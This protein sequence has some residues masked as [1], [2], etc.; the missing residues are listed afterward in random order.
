[1]PSSVSWLE[2]IELFGIQLGL[3]R[4]HALMERL[5][6]PERHLRTIHVLGTNGK[7]SVTRIA[8]ALLSAEGLSCGSFTSPHVT[9]WSERI[10]VAGREVDFE[11]AIDRVR[12]AAEE[13]GATQFEV[14][15][16]AALAEFA[17]CD[18][19][20]AV[21]E[22]GLGGRLDATNVVEAPV[23]VLTNV[24]LEHTQHLGGSREEIA[25]EKLAVVRPGARV[26]LG[27]NDWREIAEARSPSRIQLATG[28]NAELAHLAV[29]ELLGRPVD[30]RPAWEVQV[31]GR[32]EQRG[33]APL[34]IWDG[35]H[36]PAG[37]SY[38]L[39]ELP[40]GDDWTLVLSISEDKDADTMLAALSVL[41]E[42]VVATESQLG[43]PLP[44]AELAERAGRR[45]P[46]VEVVAT[47]AQALERGREL[48]GPD[49]AVLVTG[50]L[51]LL[52]S[53]N[54]VRSP[55]VRWGA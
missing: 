1:M 3:E 18:V 26:V 2:Q 14:L 42:R 44:A 54:A 4:M 43:R 45:F 31:P 50:S 21:V 11:H 25:A 23:V 35:A 49:G 5:G 8:E 15:T 10:R 52:A 39:G 6:H 30:P 37:V 53:L 51:Y 16:A 20:V 55:N 40:A 28:G 33:E 12:P 36:N 32:L 47:P 7:T 46:I 34:E 27:E 19:D 41:G 29:E 22:A 13:I 17:A 38:L 24:A 9:A 48:A